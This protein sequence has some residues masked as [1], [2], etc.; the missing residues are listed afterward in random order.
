MNK[1]LKRMLAS[2]LIAVMMLGAVS[3]SG[4]AISDSFDSNTSV[5]LTDES[6]RDGVE[7]TPE[8]P[9]VE[10]PDNEDNMSDDEFF[11]NEIQRIIAG[12]VQKVI[13]ILISYVLSFL[14]FA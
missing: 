2:L 9:D 1:M 11:E 4:F 8:E 6:F 12:F 13:D 5:V 10:A 3:V 14:T 7:T